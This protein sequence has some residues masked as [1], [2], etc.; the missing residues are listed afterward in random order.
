[1]SLF[2]AEKRFLKISSC[3]SKTLVCLFVCVGVCGCGLGGRKYSKYVIQCK[4]TPLN[5]T[6]V[7]M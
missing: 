6:G 3:K 1:M 7:V 4:H 5:N 2:I